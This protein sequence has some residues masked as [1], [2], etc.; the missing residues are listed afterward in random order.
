MTEYVTSVIKHAALSNRPMLVGQIWSLCTNS[1]SI[2]C[3]VI[4]MLGSARV[5]LQVWWIV[6]TG[7][8]NMQITSTAFPC[9][10]YFSCS[11][12][13]MGLRL[14]E[15]FRQ[16]QSPMMFS[17]CR[18]D[19]YNLRSSKLSYPPSLLKGKMR[20]KTTILNN[21]KSR[22]KTRTKLYYHER[23]LT[24]RAKMLPGNR[25]MAF[26]CLHCLDGITISLLMLS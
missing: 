18:R 25:I 26:R 20:N 9:E 23:K 13:L 7:L 14:R 10:T 21:N 4:Q 19:M 24:S 2:E 17:S 22:N 5:G 15:R 6:V 3:I 8:N 12:N 1:V 11:C 16:R